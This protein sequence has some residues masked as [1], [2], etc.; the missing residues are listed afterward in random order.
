M[1]NA[2]SAAHGGDL[3]ETRVRRADDYLRRH[4]EHQKEWYSDKASKYKKYSQYL[5]FVVIA[6][7]AAI[8]FVQTLEA[9][10]EPTR[11]AATIATAGLGVVVVVAKGAERIGR[12]E[13]TWLSY[14]KAAERMKREYRLYVNGAGAYRQASDEEDAY[15]QFVESIEEIIAEEQQLYWQGRLGEGRT[16]DGG[17]A[18]RVT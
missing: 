12:F 13:E 7:G 18:K 5:S 9:L 2:Q 14:R 16:R 8:P 15:L 4:L 6:S 17:E 11:F 1:K 3:T 10:S